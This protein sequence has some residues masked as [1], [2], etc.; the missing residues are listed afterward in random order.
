MLVVA[1]QSC[2]YQD[3]SCDFVP[4]SCDFAPL[5][6]FDLVDLGGMYY[7]TSNAKHLDCSVSIAIPQSFQGVGFRHDITVPAV[8]RD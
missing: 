5:S 3:V 8:D 6:S 1:A 2:D 7:N 4:L